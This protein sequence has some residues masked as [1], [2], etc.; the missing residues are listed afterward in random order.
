AAPAAHAGPRALRE[1][2]AVALR[3]GAQDAARDDGLVH[4]V[5]PVVDPP[6]AGHPPHERERRVVGQSEA[7]VHLDRAVDHLAE[8]PRREE[9]DERD[10]DARLVALVDP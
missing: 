10:L 4:F 5:G 7:A 8:Y 6:A 3:K 2:P 9:L 1:A